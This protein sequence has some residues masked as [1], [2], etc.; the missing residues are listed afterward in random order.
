VI[1][2]QTASSLGIDFASLS[3]HHRMMK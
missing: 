3:T 2:Q 1:D